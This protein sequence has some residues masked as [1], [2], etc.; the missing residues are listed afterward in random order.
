VCLAVA[1]SRTTFFLKEQSSLF[2]TP[3]SRNLVINP[4]LSHYIDLVAP[5]KRR[6]HESAQVFTPIGLSYYR[7]KSEPYLPPHPDQDKWAYDKIRTQWAS[8]QSTVVGISLEVTKSI[9][10]WPENNFANVIGKGIQRNLKFVMIGLKPL[11]SDSAFHAFEVDQLLKL[12]GQTSLSEMISIIGQCDLFL[13]CDSGPIHIAQAF[14]IPSIVLFGPSNEHEF[15]PVDQERH[16]LILPPSKINCR[17]CV[18][19][20]C[21]RPPGCV[22]DIPPEIVFKTLMDKVRLLN[23]YKKKTIRPASTWPK[24]ICEI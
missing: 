18:L 6:G 2:K 15:G 9:K 16:A 19:G 11:P 14:Q 7:K 12:S 1:S 22:G 20:P 4:S 8:A 10:A 3:Y 24:V 13:A 23:Q 5:Q 21:I 17:P